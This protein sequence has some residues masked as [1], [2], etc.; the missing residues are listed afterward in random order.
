MKNQQKSELEKWQSRVETFLTGQ[1]MFDGQLVRKKITWFE[2][3]YWKTPPHERADI[4]QSWKEYLD[5]TK[6]DIARPTEYDP[7]EWDMAEW[8]F[9]YRKAQARVKELNEE[10]AQS[11]PVSY[12]TEVY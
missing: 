5:P 10:L 3:V 12:A 9:E 4:L 1:Y 7:F 11:K 2:N 6:P 8:A